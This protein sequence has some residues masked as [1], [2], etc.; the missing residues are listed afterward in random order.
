[1]LGRA[2]EVRERSYAVSVERRLK[3]PAVAISQSARHELFATA[4]VPS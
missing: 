3:S 1:M 4:D 2:P